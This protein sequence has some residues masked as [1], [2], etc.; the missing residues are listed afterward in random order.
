[1]NKK[2]K[3]GRPP[4]HPRIRCIEKNKIYDTYEEAARDI[5]GFR[6][7]VRRCCY[8]KQRHHHDY[9]FEFVDE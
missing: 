1:M 7:K 9:H 3:V 4:N 6:T 8:K 5:G 2:R